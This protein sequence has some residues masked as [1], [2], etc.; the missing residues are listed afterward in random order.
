MKTCRI[1]CALSAHA[2]ATT[3]KSNRQGPDD[4]MKVSS[5]IRTNEASKTPHGSIW[6]QCGP[7]RFIYGPILS[8]VTVIGGLSSLLLMII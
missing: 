1:L 6:V 8:T 5:S 4:R 7:L 2:V 3:M